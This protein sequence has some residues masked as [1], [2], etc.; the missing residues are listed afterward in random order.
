MPHRNTDLIEPVHGVAR[1]KQAFDTCF[2]HG[3]RADLSVGRMLA[4]HGS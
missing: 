2:E 3:L 1:A 4:N